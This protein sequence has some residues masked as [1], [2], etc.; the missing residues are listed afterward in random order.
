[1]ADFEIGDEVALIDSA[2]GCYPIDSTTTTGVIGHVRELNG[3]TKFA[4]KWF[5]VGGHWYYFYSPD[6][7]EKIPR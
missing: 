2:N 1:M 7:L 6:K 3:K 5:G 4:V